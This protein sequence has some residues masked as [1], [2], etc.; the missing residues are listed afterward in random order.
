MK[1][2][3]GISGFAGSGKD[4]L[5]D[6]LCAEHGFTKLSL[7]DPMKRLCQ[8]IFGFTDEQLWGP[9][10]HREEPDARW[11]FSG[12]CPR[13][14]HCCHWN[15]ADDYWACDRCSE[16]YSEFVT[17]R[18][19]LQT[20]G[21]EWGRTLSKD[22]WGRLALR[23]IEESD[24]TLWVIPDLRFRN[25]MGAVRALPRGRLLRLTRGEQRHTHASESEM[26]ELPDDYFDYLINNRGTKAALYAAGSHIVSEW[27]TDGE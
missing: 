22:I 16:K 14:H 1:Y 3:L 13:C 27:G 7:A 23:E 21:T 12:T 10:K 8:R 15:R 2:V 11:P 17:P 25:E 26:A 4:T 24:K 20:L 19:A 9:S 6:H 18:L 5:A